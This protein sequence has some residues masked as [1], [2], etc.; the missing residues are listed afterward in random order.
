MVRHF[1]S[2]ALDGR[3]RRRD[4]NASRL[5][6]AADELLATRSFDDVSVDD[7]C[8]RADVGRATFFRIYGTK[9]GLV[10]EFNRRLADDTTDR[11]VASGSTAIR[12]VLEEIRRAII[13]A[14]KHAGRGHVGMAREFV[15][16]VPAGDPHAAHPELLEIVTGHIVAAIA[17]GQLPDTVPADLLG[18]LAL[19][20]ITAPLV[21]SGADR[22]VDIDRLSRTLLDQWHAGLVAGMPE[23]VVDVEPER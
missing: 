19:I 5:Y 15:R 12:E 16:S 3:T 11:I 20:A 8:A 10:R 17:V 7:I 14:W 2:E 21:Y 6:D 23:P 18:S 22:H 4:D 1:P 9:A 13:D